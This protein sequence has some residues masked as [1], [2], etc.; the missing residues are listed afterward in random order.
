[1]RK[2]CLKG[3]LL[4]VVLFSGIIV[5]FLEIRRVS[6]FLVIDSLVLVVFLMWFIESIKRCFQKNE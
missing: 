4:L 1:M 3:V 6:W 2:F 5:I